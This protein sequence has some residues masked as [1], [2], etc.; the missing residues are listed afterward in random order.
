MSL[1]HAL[2]HARTHGDSLLQVTKAEQLSSSEKWKSGAR[3]TREQAARRVQSLEAVVDRA[4]WFASTLAPGLFRPE[5]L[6]P[7]FLARFK[8]E[9]LEAAPLGGGDPAP[10][11]ILDFRKGWVRAGFP[12]A[13][14]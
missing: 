6:E 9:I 2:T 3:F 14:S 4:L 10:K 12:S 5:V 7:S 11:N 13:P 1:T 8:A